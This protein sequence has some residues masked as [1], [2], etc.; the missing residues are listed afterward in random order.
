M[1]KI[2]EYTTAQDNDPRGLD[3]RVTNLIEMGY[4][5]FG[6]P[7]S[8]FNGRSVT[9]CQALVKYDGDEE[10][11]AQSPEAQSPDP[12]PTPSA[13]PAKKA[14]TG[15]LTIKPSPQQVPVPPPPASPSASEP[16]AEPPTV[17]VEPLD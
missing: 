2:V 17:F 13:P 11:T 16:P 7:Y 3:K 6:G 12:Q 15:R 1:K 4:Q 9:L 5:P 8:A 10:A 14:E